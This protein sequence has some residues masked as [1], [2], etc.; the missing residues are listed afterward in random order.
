M[1]TLRKGSSLPKSVNKVFLMGHL[2]RD[3]EIKDNPSARAVITLAT[4]EWQKI[5]NGN[6][7]EFK[8]NTTWH[9]IYCWGRLVE[10]AQAMKKGDF[11]YIEGKLEAYTYEN[12][13]GQKNTLI[14]VKAW[15]IIPMALQK[16]EKQN[17][18]SPKNNNGFTNRTISRQSEVP[19]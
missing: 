12:D 3:P 16:K 15:D 13:Q 7:E 18:Q 10:K 2:G 9:R 8:E 4:T 11:C 6:K 1:L 14:Y 19:F 5:Q 17:E